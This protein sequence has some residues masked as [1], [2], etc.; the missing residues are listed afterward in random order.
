MHIASPASATDWAAYY[1]LRYEVLRQPWQQPEGSER[2]DDDLAPTT[3]HALVLAPEGY[4]TAVGRVHPSGPGQGQMRF[5]A[6]HPA[7]QGRGL[8]GQ[9]LGYLEEA[10]RQQG[11]REIVLHAREN[12]VPFYQR[13]GYTVVEPSHTLFGQIPHFLMRKHLS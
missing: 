4:A 5:M 7:W 2:A 10:A 3:T 12:A 11:L 8:G 6:V 13:H 1:H 9:V